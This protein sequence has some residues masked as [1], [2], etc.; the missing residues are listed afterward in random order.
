MDVSRYPGTHAKYPGIGYQVNTRVSGTWVWVVQSLVT[1]E[2]SPALTNLVTGQ[3]DWAKMDIDGKEVPYQSLR[4][5]GPSPNE[6]ILESSEHET[7][8][9]GREKSVS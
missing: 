5:S 7:N 2:N 9:G 3:S 6:S 4:E 8:G 1:T